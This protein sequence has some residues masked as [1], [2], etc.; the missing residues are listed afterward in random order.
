MEVS[1]NRGVECVDVDVGRFWS[2][3]EG[4]CTTD[5][6]TLNNI[7]MG[8]CTATE[9]KSL[10]YQRAVLGSVLV[11]NIILWIS[12]HVSFTLTIHGICDYSL[13]HIIINDK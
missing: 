7:I 3:R 11:V 9:S 5:L 13:K 12:T 8:Q 10:N 4:S 6:S 1:V 2:G